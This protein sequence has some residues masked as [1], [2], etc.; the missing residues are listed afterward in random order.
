MKR[1]KH[2]DGCKYWYSAGHPKNSRHSAHNSWCCAKGAPA[3]ESTG[4]CKVHDKKR[5]DGQI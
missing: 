2:C 5:L 4:W 3:K 1:P